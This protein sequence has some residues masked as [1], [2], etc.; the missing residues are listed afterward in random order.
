MDFGIHENHLDGS[1][2]QLGMYWIVH[3][4]LSDTP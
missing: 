1:T 2:E 3:Y 4:R